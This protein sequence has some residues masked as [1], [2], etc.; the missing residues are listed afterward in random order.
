MIPV[1]ATGAR[2]ACARN[3]TRE[4]VFQRVELRQC[5]DD[6]HDV[7]VIG[8]A[9][10]TGVKQQFGHK[11]PDDSEGHSEFPQPAL[12]VGETGSNL[13]SMRDIVEDHRE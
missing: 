6:G 3:D 10:G 9:G 8:H 1:S 7:G 4:L 13:G 2:G 5:L 11:R 12:D